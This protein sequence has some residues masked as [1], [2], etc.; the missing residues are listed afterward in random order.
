MMNIHS[1]SF[2]HEIYKLLDAV[3]FSYK[4]YH[5]DTTEELCILITVLFGL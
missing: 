2:S 4:T 1:Y 5:G 3:G